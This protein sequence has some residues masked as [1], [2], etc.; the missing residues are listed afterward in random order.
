MKIERINEHKR[1]SLPCPKCNRF[2]LMDIVAKFKIGNQVNYSLLCP[3]CGCR[4]KQTGRRFNRWR[5]LK[6][7]HK[8]NHDELRT[9]QK[10]FMQKELEKLKEQQ[11]DLDK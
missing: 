1:I 10:D 7:K 2:G 9:M 5:D 11:E 4:F 8:L 6:K 3:E